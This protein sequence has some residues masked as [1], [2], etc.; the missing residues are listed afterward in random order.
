MNDA[1]K[2]RNAPTSFGTQAIARGLSRPT[3]TGGISLNRPP[4]WFVG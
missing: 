4:Q 2:Q 1:L 3:D